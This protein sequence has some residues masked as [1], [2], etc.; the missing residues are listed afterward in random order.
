MKKSAVLF[1]SL[2]ILLM[3][4]TSSFAEGNN[5]N[6]AKAHKVTTGQVVFKN[7]D[8]SPSQTFSGT[9]NDGI[10][11][12]ISIEKVQS[13][14]LEKNP[15]TATADALEV[16]S[17]NASTDAL[18]ENSIAS[19][20][21]TWKVSHDGGPVQSSFYMVVTDNRVIS[22]YDRWILVLAGTYENVS[23]TKDYYSNARLAFD[24]VGLNGMWENS[25][26]LKGTITGTNNWI[27]VS[28][29]Y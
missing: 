27:T 6:I 9:D 13:R 8:K 12:T 11:Y 25:C 23:F 24:A 3:I 4:T 1:L 28:Y 22:A 5:Q 17:I 21:N 10:P 29:Q 20:T 14:D 19:T 15:I 2:V 18:T 16:D 26:W 7:L